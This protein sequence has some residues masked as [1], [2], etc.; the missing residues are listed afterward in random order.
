MTNQLPPQFY[1]LVNELAV[2]YDPSRAMWLYALVQVLIED[3]KVQVVKESEHEQVVR[4]ILPEDDRQFSIVRPGMS[5]SLETL[6]I[7]TMREMLQDNQ[8]D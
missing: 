5:A 8:A 6:L 3:G 2:Q 1:D 4:V 7:K